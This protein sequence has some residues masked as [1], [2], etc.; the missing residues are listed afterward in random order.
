MGEKTNWI[1]TAKATWLSNTS[2]AAFP[3]LS[4]IEC[5]VTMLCNKSRTNKVGLSNRKRFS[6][7][8]RNANNILGHGNI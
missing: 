8:Y 7:S 5:S 4:G 1:D 3:L 2:L 6:N